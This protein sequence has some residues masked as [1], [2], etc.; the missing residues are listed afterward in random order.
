MAITKGQL[1]GL[2]GA[3]Y[4]DMNPSSIKISGVVGGTGGVSTFRGAGILDAQGTIP[5][6]NFVTTSTGAGMGGI[7][8]SSRPHTEQMLDRYSLNE[9]QVEHRVTEFELMKLRETDVDYADHIKQN[10]AKH[11]SEE[12]TRKM[13]FTKKKQI[14]SDTT[15]FR[16]RVWVFSK[17]ELIQMIEEIRNGI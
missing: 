8:N 10:L 5:A 16:G 13:S 11:A 4:E 15:S 2:T 6:G 14:D 12:V 3:M 9:L 7:T 17:E 1:G